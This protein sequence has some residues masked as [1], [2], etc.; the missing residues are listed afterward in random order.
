MENFEDYSPSK[1][2]AKSKTYVKE[3]KITVNKI[4]FFEKKSET[5]NKNIT[6]VEDILK[7]YSGR[8]FVDDIDVK[9]F[10]LTNKKLL[11]LKE[12]L[13]ENNNEIIN[14]IDKK[15]NLELQ[16]KKIGEI[17]QLNEEKVCAK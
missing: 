5:I 10:D 4:K 17:L 12:D 9:I 2:S 6:L 8:S 13:F 3:L 11:S 15:N 7:K 1:L 14:L 16:I